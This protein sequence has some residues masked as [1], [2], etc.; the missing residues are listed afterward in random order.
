MK[1]P[2]VLAATAAIL[3]PIPGTATA[4]TGPDLWSQAGCGSCHTLQASGSTGTAGPNLDQIRPSSATVAA[5]V[6]YGGGGMPAFGSS[7]TATQIQELA[8]WVA[9]SAGGAGTTTAP[10]S[11]V[12][13][14]PAAK[15]KKLQNALH[16]FGYFNGPVTGFYG[17][18]TTKAVKKFQR[19]AGLHPDG[20][21]GPLSQAALVRQLP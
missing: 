6:T 18:I 8:S 9:S 3:A 10:A 16:R 2:H 11:A 13:G 14:M 5:Q 20:I 12:S 7:L 15:V 19:A 17:P 1:R 4:A 21:W